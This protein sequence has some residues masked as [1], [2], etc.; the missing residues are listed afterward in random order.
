MLLKDTSLDA[1]TRDVSRVIKV[2]PDE[3]TLRN[4]ETWR[5]KIELIKFIQNM[6]S[7]LPPLPQFT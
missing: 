4:G 3:F 7:N 2:D 5:E 1:G 6:S